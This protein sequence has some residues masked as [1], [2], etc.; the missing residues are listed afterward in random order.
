MTASEHIQYQRVIIFIRK[1]IK[2]TSSLMDVVQAIN[3]QYLI[4]L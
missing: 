2:F 1:A 4:H 3:Y